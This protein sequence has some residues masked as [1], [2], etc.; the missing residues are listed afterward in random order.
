MADNTG[1][2][3]QESL[4]RALAECERLKKENE[5]FRQKLGAASELNNHNGFKSVLVADSKISS[6]ITLL[7]SDQ[8]ISLFRSLFRG[9]DDVYAVRW[10]NKK[11]KS[12]YSPACGN[13]WAHGICEKPRVKCSECPNQKF[14][15]ITDKII[16][17]HL[18]GRKTI[19]VYPL[20]TDETC[21]FLAVDFD[22]ENWLED[23]KTFLHTCREHE[24]DAV[25]E[26]SQSGKGGHV[27]IFFENPI[28]ASL[29]R[30]LGSFLLT[31][32]ME[33]RHQ[34]GLQSYDRLFP[35]Q[36]TMPKGGFG[37]LI[38]LPLQREPRSHG[39]SAFIDENGILHSDQ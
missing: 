38:A 3:L 6:E 28:S 27:W 13:E 5:Y 8:K 17:D 4:D 2:R 11:G 31:K 21:W 7:S 33:R 12:G 14:L 19:G 1:N 18:T 34:M 32:A 29:A 25:L 22:K 39:N 10:Q 9:R 36:D 15:P 30:K 20:L 26:R 35:N 23:A 16:Q 24:I 37:N